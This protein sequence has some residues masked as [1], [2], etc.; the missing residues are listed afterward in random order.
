[1]RTELHGSTIQHQMKHRQ[2]TWSWCR[3]WE[4]R[5]KCGVSKNGIQ[6]DC[7][8]HISFVRN[9]DRPMFE[10][11]LSL[12][13]LSGQIENNID[14]QQNEGTQSTVN[15]SYK[16]WIKEQNQI[17]TKVVIDRAHSLIQK[18]DGRNISVVMKVMTNQSYRSDYFLLC[19]SRR[20]V[21][22]RGLYDLFINIM[23]SCKHCV[24]VV[25]MA[26]FFK[27]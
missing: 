24:S 23:Q 5:E 4:D 17:V 12:E 19:V 27:S 3:R 16:G 6:G 26:S 2:N 11:M 13:R 20:C 7:F 21:R 15:N 10:R 25:C 18:K 22:I 9:S 14:E 8:K 1:M